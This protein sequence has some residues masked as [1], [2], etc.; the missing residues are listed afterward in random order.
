MSELSISM[1]SNSKILKSKEQSSYVVGIIP[2]VIPSTKLKLIY[3]ATENGWYQADFR[4][5]CEGKAPTVVLAKTDKGR[6]CGG[7][8]SLKWEDGNFREDP[9]QVAFSVDKQ[10]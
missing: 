2:D 9:K 8:T 4:A 10:L 3:R 1:L 6:I 7:Y 5:L